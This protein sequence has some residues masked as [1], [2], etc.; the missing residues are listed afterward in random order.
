MNERRKI[1]RL[2]LAIGAVEDG[3][4]AQCT[5][6]P[7]AT[8]LPHGRTAAESKQDEDILSNF[9]DPQSDNPQFAISLRIV[10]VI[11]KP[12]EVETCAR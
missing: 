2:A 3:D 6:V 11:H 12:C 9:V 7:R 8:R 10:A 1:S 5:E 4:I